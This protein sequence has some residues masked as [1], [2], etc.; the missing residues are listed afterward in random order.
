[1][2]QSVMRHSAE[3]HAVARSSMPTHLA[4]LPP[5]AIHCHHLHSWSTLEGTVLGFTML[6]HRGPARKPA[7]LRNPLQQPTPHMVPSLNYS[8][9]HLIVR[10]VYS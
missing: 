10:S 3:D 9:V 4:A 1:M 7:L 5:I 6:Q 2:V 8:C